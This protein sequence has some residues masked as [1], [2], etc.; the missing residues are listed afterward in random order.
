VRRDLVAAAIASELFR[1]VPGGMHEPP[2]GYGPA[3]SFKTGE[4]HGNLQLTFFSSLQP[5][6]TFK[7]DADI[8]DA[9]G[10]GHVFQVL[11]NTLT[12]GTTHPY[13]IHQILVF[14]Q[15]PVFYDLA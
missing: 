4:R 10:L 14:R 9:A 7:V 6:P 5:P 13:D 2:V 3:G 12:R 11:R 1:D 15:E 8:D